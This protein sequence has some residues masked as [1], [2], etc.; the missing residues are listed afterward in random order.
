MIAGAGAVG[1]LDAADRDYPD[2]SEE[3]GPG[4][5][6][7]QLAA[8]GLS[9]NGLAI[10]CDTDPGFRPGAFSHPDRAVRRATIKLTLRGIDAGRATGGTPMTLWVGQDGLDHAF[11][12]DSAQAWH[13]TVAAIAHNPDEPPACA[14]MPDIGTTLP[15]CHAV[16]RPDPGVRLAAPA[17]RGCAW[18]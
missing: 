13:D 12:M 18:W 4:D 6:A 16:A 17:R 15:A 14:L 11:Q 8:A 9:L 2:H 1:G 3:K 5:P 10:R 7:G